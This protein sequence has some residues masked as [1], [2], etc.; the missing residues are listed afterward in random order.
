MPLKLQ[1]EAFKLIF[2]YLATLV[3]VAVYDRKPAEKDMDSIS[4]DTAHW[5]TEADHLVEQEKQ[6]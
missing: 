3:F 2:R 5:M 6:S 4:F 1:V